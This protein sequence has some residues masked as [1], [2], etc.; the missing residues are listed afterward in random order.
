MSDQH[1]RL[2]IEFDINEKA[3][4]N[5]G[6]T[7]TDVFKNITL[8]NEEAVNRLV[9]SAAVPGFCPAGN[10]F[11]REGKL[12]FKELA[13]QRSRDNI[14]LDG[15]PNLGRALLPDINTFD[16]LDTAVRNILDSVMQ[17][18]PCRGVVFALAENVGTDNLKFHF[19]QAGKPL[20][21]FSSDEAE[22]V[23]LCVKEQPSLFRGEQVVLPI[24][25]RNANVFGFLSVDPQNDVTNGQLQLLELFAQHS[26]T[27]V[28]NAKLHDLVQEKSEQMQRN[29]LELIQ[30]MRRVV[31]FKDPYTRGHSDRVSF[32]AY[33]LAR[34]IGK[35]DA[36]CERV[37]V[38]GLFHDIGKLSIP[39][40]ILLKPS[41]LT[42]E[43]IEII[44]SHSANG[45]ELLS[46]LSLFQH[47]LPTVR[48]HHERID[49][50]GYPDRLMG[51]EI[52]EEARIISVVDTFDAMTS[53]RQYRSA[54][55]LH[56]ALQEMRH[57]RG[58]QL[59]A[60]L[61]DAFQTLIQTPEFW[62]SARAEMG[63]SFPDQ[64]YHEWNIYVGA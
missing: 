40:E 28:S 32:Y 59:E 38:A 10:C 21:E 4:H 18:L 47:I 27:A 41:R 53:S 15:F 34:H 52:P 31:D 24:I 63:E 42:D 13:P 12:T 26:T 1:V 56:R 64:L 6:I 37:R 23:L 58:K 55:I 2:T 39:D 7:A 36:F 33:Q 46:A 22:Q 57:C 30:A 9:I 48:A 16:S 19:R 25:N 60:R 61:V 45:A 29:Y 43:E 3:L 5:C 54:L 35:N 20:R 14:Y 62:S 49:G 17:F 50:N 8:C 11:F 51:D 44:R